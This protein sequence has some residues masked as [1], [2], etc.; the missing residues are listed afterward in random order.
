MEHFPNLPFL[1]ASYGFTHLLLT[2]NRYK[3]DFS[4]VVVIKV[5]FEA[6]SFMFLLDFLNLLFLEFSDL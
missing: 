2:Q 6:G 5:A 1:K 4:E 3:Q